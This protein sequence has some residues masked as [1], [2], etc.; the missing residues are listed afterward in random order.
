[1]KVNARCNLLRRLAGTKCGAHFDVLQ[2]TTAF[3]TCSVA[4]STILNQK[5]GEEY[6]GSVVGNWKKTKVVKVLQAGRQVLELENSGAALAG[7]VFA[8]EYT[9]SSRA[10]GNT[11]TRQRHLKLT[12]PYMD[13]REVP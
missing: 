3:A 7:V 12:K 2:T 11:K 8:I 6:C 1:M 10:S 4:Y 5:Q 9:E 13:G